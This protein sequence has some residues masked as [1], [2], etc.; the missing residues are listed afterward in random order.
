MNRNQLTYAISTLYIAI[1]LIIHLVHTLIMLW[2][3]FWGEESVIFVPLHAGFNLIYLLGLLVYLYLLIRLKI[4]YKTTLMLIIWATSMGIILIT[5]SGLQYILFMVAIS[6][7]LINECKSC[8]KVMSL[9]FCSFLIFQSYQSSLVKYLLSLVLFLFVSVFS[10]S[11]LV[12]HPYSLNTLFVVDTI[13]T[14]VISFQ[15]ES[16]AMEYF[17]VKSE[18]I[19]PH[20]GSYMVLGEM[21]FA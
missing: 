19:I 8:I 1:V 11:S 10:V 6:F 4:R 20:I 9:I 15:I 14:K 13:E 7:Y 18:L 12:V 16:D 17:P 2:F 5:S 21:F 3:H